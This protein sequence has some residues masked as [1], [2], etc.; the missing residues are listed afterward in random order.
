MKV[1]PTVFSCK[2]CQK[3][4]RNFF[5]FTPKTEMGEARRK[6]T[7]IEKV[8]GIILRLLTILVMESSSMAK[9]KSGHQVRIVD[10]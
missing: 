5:S 2:K 10:K 1:P 7:N 4:K 3:N 8:G 9:W 6:K